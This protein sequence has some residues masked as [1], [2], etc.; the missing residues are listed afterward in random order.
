MFWDFSLNKRKITTLECQK[1]LFPVNHFFLLNA[2]RKGSKRL[3]DKSHRLFPRLRVSPNRNIIFCV[4]ESHPIHLESM[5][6]QQPKKLPIHINWS[7]NQKVFQHSAKLY[8]IILLFSYSKII[9]TKMIQGD[10]NLVH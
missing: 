4:N 9:K 8:K 1:Q 2:I 10:P 5:E 7:P 6:L 3:I